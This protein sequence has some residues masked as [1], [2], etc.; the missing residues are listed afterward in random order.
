L[1]E[2]F[3]CSDRSKQNTIINILRKGGERKRGRWSEDREVEGEERTYK[4]R[5]GVS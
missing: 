2:I 4:L 3:G 5:I 1:C